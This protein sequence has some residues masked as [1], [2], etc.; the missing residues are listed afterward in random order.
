M[1]LNDKNVEDLLNMA[2]KSTEEAIMESSVMTRASQKVLDSLKDSLTQA[3]KTK[4][5]V[6]QK[7]KLKFKTLETVDVKDIIKDKTVE[8]TLNWVVSL[9]QDV[10]TR[11]NDQGEIL[12]FLVEKVSHVLDKKDAN[13]EEILKQKQAEL[14]TAL[15]KQND[16]ET[17]LN[18]KHS[19]LENEMRT[20]TDNLEKELL[21][22][23]NDLEIKCDEA[24][25][26]GLKGNLIVS[27]PARNTPRGLVTHAYQQ[28][29]QFPYGYRRE[30]MLEMVLRLVLTKTNVRIPPCDVVACH[31]IG[32]RDS[33]TFILSVANRTPGSAWDLLTKGM[34]TGNN[35]TRDNIFINFQLTKR[36]GAIS[37]EVRKAKTDNLIEKF[38]TDANGRIFV[39]KNGAKHEISSLKDLYELTNVET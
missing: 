26:R 27:A 5:A 39:T 37:K 36:R 11:I 33:Y 35:F 22:K 16:L 19:E 23:C 7:I 28:E 20:K 2:K 12:A 32:A 8:T 25:Q 17:A 15:Q 34:A 9:F 31:P 21:A 38:K 24:R 18:Q 10:I 4:D 29:R 30:N 6:A 1:P 3:G 14:E 13:V